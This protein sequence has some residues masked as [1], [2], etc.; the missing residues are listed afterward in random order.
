MEK[1]T[2]SVTY[3]VIFVNANSGVISTLAHGWT[4]DTL[5][6]Y[7]AQMNRRRI[8]FTKMAPM[9][10]TIQSG[11]WIIAIPLRR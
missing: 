1:T 3:D 6:G 8:G 9:A 5:D 7:I 11:S 2:E 10:W 4:M